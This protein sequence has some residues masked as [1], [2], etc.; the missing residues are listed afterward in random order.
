MKKVIEFVKQVRT[1]LVDVHTELRKSSWPT[2][3]ELMESTAVV[4][5]SVV[6]F[7]VFVGIS[8]MVLRRLIDLLVR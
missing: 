4:V 3:G 6:I 1:F 5:I 7:A 8:D 2:R